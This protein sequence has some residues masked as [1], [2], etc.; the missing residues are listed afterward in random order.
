MRITLNRSR[1]MREGGFAGISAAAIGAVAAATVAG[2]AV[3][4][5]TQTPGRSGS[6]GGA[7]GGTMSEAA[8]QKQ[9]VLIAEQAANTDA[10]ASVAAA[11]YAYE[12]ANTSKSFFTYAAAVG[13]GLLVYAVLKKEKVL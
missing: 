10:Q 3:Y 8:F 13:V 2:V 9:Q 1:A 12:Q 4:S 5:A 6:G 7:Q 11:N